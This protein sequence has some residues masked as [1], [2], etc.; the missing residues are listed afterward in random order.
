V[1]EITSFAEGGAYDKFFFLKD[2][3]GNNWAVQEVPA[4]RPAQQAGAEG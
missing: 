3:D 1:S 4:V 2:P